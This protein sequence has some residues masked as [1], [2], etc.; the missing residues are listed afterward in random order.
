MWPSPSLNA[1]MAARPARWGPAV[2][3]L[4]AA[5]TASRLSNPA[6]WSASLLIAA[7]S[8]HWLG[9]VYFCDLILT[10]VD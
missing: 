8:D 9:F 10:R 2:H 1:R 6:T 5:S 4:L 3:D 7:P